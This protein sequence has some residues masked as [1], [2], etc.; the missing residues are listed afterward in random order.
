[1]VLQGN[2]VIEFLFIVIEVAK[3]VVLEL[4]VLLNYGQVEEG[5]FFAGYSTSICL[6]KG[7]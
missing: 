1:M 3:D 4:V 5:N 6:N 2:K 7:G